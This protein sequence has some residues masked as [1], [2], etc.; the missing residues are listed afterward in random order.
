MV[1]QTSSSQPT[2][3]GL[4]TVNSPL[5]WAEW[6]KALHEHPDQRFSSFL[7]GGIKQGFRVGF[8]PCQLLQPTEE[9]MSSAAINPTPVT[10]Y[11][12]TE[13][14]AGRVLG[15][16]QQPQAAGIQ[17]SRFGVIPK[18]RQPG[19]W[20]L[21]LDLS[22]PPGRSVNDGVAKELSSLRYASVDDAARIV[23]QMGPGTQLAKIDIAHAYRNVP[24][25]PDD[26]YLLGMQWEN[27]IYIDTALP[28]GLRS[29]PKIF[30]A[31][32]DTL[33]WILLRQGMSSC[34]HYLDD[35][36]TM[37]AADSD[38]CYR[39]LE[40][41]L[42]ICEVLGLPVAKHKVEGP[43]TKLE[44]LGIEFDTLRM[45]MRLPSEKLERLKELLKEWLGK[46][47]AKKRMI[48]SLIGSRFKSSTTR[49]N[50]SA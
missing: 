30:S 34:L 23:S 10:E 20:R 25:H 37:G 3:E 38:E 47:S 29:A 28:F 44:F 2:L 35:F 27:H 19:K 33:E 17:I 16:F 4:T 24:V 42:R 11:L 22:Y 36:L 8:N 32:S 15:P 13:L 1:P 14:A 5:V 49:Q 26:R 6:C 43:T 45:L 39:N 46:K 41:M 40:L 18:K 7:L 50:F 48:L 31:I 21:I 9:N 12:Q